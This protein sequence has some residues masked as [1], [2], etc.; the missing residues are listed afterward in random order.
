MKQFIQQEE[1]EQCRQRKTMMDPANM[2]PA[3]PFRVT[4][5]TFLNPSFCI[6]LLIS[7]LLS[8]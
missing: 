8:G 6:Y 3:A 7:L 1:L 2:V 4:A 5:P